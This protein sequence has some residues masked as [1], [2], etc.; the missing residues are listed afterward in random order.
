M[1]DLVPHLCKHPIGHTGR[2]DDGL[3]YTW[4]NNHP[5]CEGC[6]ERERWARMAMQRAAEAERDLELLRSALP[7]LLAGPMP[8]SDPLELLRIR[9][10]LAAL[11]DDDWSPADWETFSL[12]Q[13]R[14]R[15]AL[16]TR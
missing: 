16:E 1:T 2:C 14:A 6:V 9:T 10:V 3:G 4:R 5:N 8:E 15:E 7:V 12:E 11:P 13:A